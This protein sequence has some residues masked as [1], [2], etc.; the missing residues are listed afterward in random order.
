MVLQLEWAVGKKK[1]LVWGGVFFC[2]VLG[3]FPHNTA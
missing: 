2:F 3:F 1:V